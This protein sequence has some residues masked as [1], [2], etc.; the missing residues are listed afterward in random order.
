MHEPNKIEDVRYWL[1]YLLDQLY[2]TNKLDLQECERCL[3]E[4]CSVV[5]IKVPKEEIA[6]ER[7]L[8]PLAQFKAEE[9]KTSIEDWKKWNNRYLKELKISK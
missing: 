3:E 1:D 5:G 8:F 4:L 9:K 2:S 7:K 6:I